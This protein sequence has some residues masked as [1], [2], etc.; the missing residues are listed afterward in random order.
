M[1]ATSPIYSCGLE[2]QTTFH[3]HLHCNLFST[4]GVQLLND[5]HSHVPSI[6]NYSNS[7]LLNIILYQ[8]EEFSF[9]VK[10]EILKSNF[11]QIFNQISKNIQTF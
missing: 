5:I 9:N 2:P 4:L 6:R 11:N 8:S 1:D 7:N 10:K 3:Y